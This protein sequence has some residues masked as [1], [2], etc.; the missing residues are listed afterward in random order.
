MSA[1]T[2]AACRNLV[3]YELY[4]RNHGPT[5]TFEDVA[6][7]T[8]RLRALGVDYVW[9]MPIHPIGALYRKG[10]LGSP[11]SV[12]DFFAVNPEQGTEQDFRQLVEVIH[13]SGM[14][15]MYDVVF[16]HTAHDSDLVRDHL[17]WY[18]RGIDGGPYRA[19]E[20]WTDIV[21][22]KHPNDA[23][24][25]YLISVLQHWA[26]FGVDGFRCD[27]ASLLPRAFW[28]EARRAVNRRHP[29]I[30]W[31]AESISGGFIEHQRASGL[32]G[33]SDSELYETFDLT[34]DYD[35][36]PI[37]L[38]AVQGRVP[39]RRYLE[40]L[41]F[42]GC[43]YPENYAK[44]RCVENHDGLAVM[45]LAPSEAQALAWTAFSAFT[46]G[47][48][49]IHAGQEA[50]A[51][52]TPSLFERDPI[53]WNGYRLQPWLARL[54]R[55][56]KH[57]AQMDGRFVV[58]ADE[59]VIQAV[60]QHSSGILY[61]MF[62]VGAQHGEVEVRLADGRYID[63]LT[64]HA[65]DVQEGRIRLPETAWIVS[66]PAAA[67]FKAFYSELLDFAPS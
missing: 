19:L 29:H 8:P 37:W 66:G 33:L 2:P 55:L 62:N 17:E 30:L 3:I 67:G 6:A 35:I 7:D 24:S 57:P 11:Y 58:I 34:Y 40:M 12:R 60:W 50:G 32:H 38:A 51:R 52:K 10:R 28:S 43:I 61:G 65:L 26:D 54:A 63:L 1:H 42:Q 21:G 45:A 46:C 56:K 44:L 47:A 25:A 4:I 9:L 27:A 15:V 23:L 14:K 41:R 36:W 39:V 53:D 16:N 64:D 13:A 5:G 31:L 48:W 49:M 18:H 59:P 22:F 20:G